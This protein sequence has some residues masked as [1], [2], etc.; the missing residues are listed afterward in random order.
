MSDAKGVTIGS[1]KEFA[2]IGERGQGERVY[3]R[4]VAGKI[5]LA[6]LTAR[7]VRLVK[8]K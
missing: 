8:P 5:R 1:A 4:L 7:P 2:E 6:I 3:A